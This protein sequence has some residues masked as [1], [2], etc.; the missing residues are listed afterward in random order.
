MLRTG[1]N[2]KTNFSTDFSLRLRRNTHVILHR[3][4]MAVGLT[5]Y[6]EVKL[7]QKVSAHVFVECFSLQTSIPAI[8]KVGRVAR[9]SS[10][11]DILMSQL[12]WCN[13]TFLPTL[14]R[15]NRGLAHQGFTVNPI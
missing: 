11:T 6:F 15:I 1:A 12:S 14:N 13:Y 9:L 8:I 5:E 3:K 10:I 2:N 7:P 4:P